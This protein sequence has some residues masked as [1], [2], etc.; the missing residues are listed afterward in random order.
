M[1]SFSSGKFQMKVGKSFLII[2]GGL[3]LIFAMFRLAK[4]IIKNEL[5]NKWMDIFLGNVWHMYHP[6]V[7]PFFLHIIIRSSTVSSI[8]CKCRVG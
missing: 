4:V 8:D 1:A 5:A 6:N 7:P 3:N 2:L